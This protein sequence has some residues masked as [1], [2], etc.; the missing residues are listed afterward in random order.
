MSITKTSGIEADGSCIFLVVGTH[1]IRTIKI[2]YGDSMEK[3][4]VLEMGSQFI[5]AVTPGTYKPE[6]A[7]VTL[8]NSVWRA[9]FLPR[10][11][12]FGSANSPISAIVQTTI[13]GLGQDTDLWSPCYY[14]GSSLSPDNTNKSVD[15]DLTFYV[16]QYWWGDSRRTINSLAGAFAI[17]QNTL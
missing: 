3:S 11:P 4:P 14:V 10:L 15:V 17:G 13:P 7:K 1:A 8:R 2:T 5:S 6:A 16:Q 12:I 9:E